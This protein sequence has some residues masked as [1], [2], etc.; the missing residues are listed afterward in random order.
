MESK[1]RYREFL[2]SSRSRVTERGRSVD[3]P[4]I[5]RARRRR[6]IEF[7][8]VARH[9]G[10]SQ[11]HFTAGVDEAYQDGSIQFY[12]LAAGSTRGALSD[13][14]GEGAQNLGFFLQDDF[15]VNDRLSLVLG[16]R[17]DRVVY[18]YRSFLPTA[19]I[20]KQS[21]DFDR[22]S[23]KLGASWM[24]GKFS[25]IYANVGGGTSDQRS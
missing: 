14:K 21:K 17:Y 2:V 15:A 24:L 4:R 11:S 3:H 12:A 6:S 18:N 16:G 23:P 22:L 1:T 20:K 19:T 10:S 9:S 25:S 13:N 8:N 7:R 5:R